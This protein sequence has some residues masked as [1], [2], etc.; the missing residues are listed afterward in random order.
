MTTVGPTFAGAGATSGSPA[1][2]SPGSITASDDVRAQCGVAALGTSG[3]LKATSF[4]FA[5][6]AGATINGITVA[7]ER[8]STS[9]SVIKDST[10]QLLKAGTAAGSNK[11]DTGTFWP[12]N[13]DS[14][15]TYGSAS[16]LWGTS[17]AASDIND[18]NFGVQIITS[19]ADTSVIR[20]S[21]VDAVKITIDYTASAGAAPDVASRLLLLGVQ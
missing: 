16:D 5:I 20:Q 1:W 11:A 21:Q 8:R 13:V 14:T 3:T 4:G 19:N 18:V 6:P 15:A 10:I 12:N 2:T 17:W 9:A 7:I